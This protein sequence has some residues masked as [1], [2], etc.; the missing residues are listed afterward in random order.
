MSGWGVTPAIRV[1]DMAAGLQFYRDRIGFAVERGGPEDSNVSLSFG[2]ARLML[3]VPA[4]FYSESYN[5]A[6]RRRMG[7]ASPHALYMEAPD[8]DVLYGRVNAQGIRI[9]DP[10]ADRP[11]G[12]R[13]FTVE[14]HE[15]NWLTFWEVREAS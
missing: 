15:G 2:D 5:S 6:I 8:I 10:L 11:W 12:Q 7:N 3:E 13:E 9:V 4:D 14:D 1:T